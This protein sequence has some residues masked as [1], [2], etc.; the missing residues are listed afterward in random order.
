MK[1]ILSIIK[2][3]FFR[4]FK[5]TRLMF[6]TVI[7]PGLMIFVV[8][9]VMGGAIT[10]QFTGDS[11]YVHKVYVNEI[12]DS[13][14]MLL[15]ASEIKIEKISF[16]EEKIDE[17]KEKITEKEADLFLASFIVLPF[18]IAFTII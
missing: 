8:Y 13:I 2:K 17:V 3:E 9:S 4:F 15:E 12:P 7:L 16:D 11:E 1:N 5:D 6:T 18:S 14:N 10:D